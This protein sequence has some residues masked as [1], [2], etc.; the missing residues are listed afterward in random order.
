MTFGIHIHL[1][2]FFHIYSVKKKLEKF[3][4]FLKIIVFVDYFFPIFEIFNIFKIRDN[5]L[6]EVFILNLLLKIN[7][8]CLL[9]YLLDS[10]SRKP[11]F[12][13]KNGKTL[14]HF[15]VIYG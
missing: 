8:F 10:V 15:D 1:K 12:L 4:R 3:Y 2:V 14:S 5:S 7:R 11:L 13:P 9:N 6:I